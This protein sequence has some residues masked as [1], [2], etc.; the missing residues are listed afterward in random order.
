MK[1]IGRLRPGATAQS[2]QAEFTLLAKQLDSEH[3][4]RNPVTPRLSPLK[5]HVS[6]RVRPGADGAGLCG[7]S[8]DVDCV[9][10]SFESAT[11]A[12][13]RRGKRKWRCGPR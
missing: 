4:E 8:G 3:P 12:A 9:R 5:Q 6:G 2:A 11:G 13:G 10:E 1:A 7:G